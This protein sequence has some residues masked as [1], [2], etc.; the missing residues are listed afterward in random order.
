MQGTEN[1]E[2]FLQSEME[3][4][5]INENIKVCAYDDQQNLIEYTSVSKKVAVL[6]PN[7]ISEFILALSV[8]ARKIGETDDEITLIVPEHLVALCKS[9]STLPVIPYSRKNS[10]QFLDSVSIVKEKSFDKLYILPHSFSSAWFGAKTGI[11]KSRGISAEQRSH[12]LTEGI[13]SEIVSKNEHLTKEYSLVLETSYVEPSFWPGI[14]VDVDKH[15]YGTV[16]LCPGADKPSCCWDGFEG[17]V[18]LW[19]DQHFVILGEDEDYDLSKNIGKRLPHRVVN[20]VGKTSIS[21]RLSILAG[22]SVVI[23]ND[24]G[25]LQIAGYLGTPV[26]G[27]FGGTTPIWKQP[28]GGSAYIV[29]SLI[30]QCRFCNKRECTKKKYECLSTIFPQNVISSA[31]AIMR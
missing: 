13:P 31:L 30:A 10:I 15:F 16:V 8:V 14:T 5:E 28:L 20:L 7:W 26:V 25:L 1:S 4:I 18:K 29:T 19:P 27:I 12:F 2:A 22:A 6:M 17:L 9:L 21:E 3:I 24:N 11:P 23:A